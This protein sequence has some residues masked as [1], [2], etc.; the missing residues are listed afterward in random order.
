MYYH[1][2]VGW[3][4]IRSLN[5]HPRC[6]FLSHRKRLKLAA[7]RTAE[8]IRKLIERSRYPRR[9]AYLEERMQKIDQ[10]LNA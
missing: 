8:K 5:L 1:D 3:G 2:S 7:E 10:K 6:Q 4:S 9:L